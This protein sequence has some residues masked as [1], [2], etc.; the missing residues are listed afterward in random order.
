MLL[1][2]REKKADT[3]EQRTEQRAFWEF[4]INFF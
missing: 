4:E 3:Q 2:E 1:G